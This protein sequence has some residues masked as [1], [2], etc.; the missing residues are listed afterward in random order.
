MHTNKP[1][2]SKFSFGSCFESPFSRGKNETPGTTTA[3]ASSSRATTSSKRQPRNCEHARL[4]VVCEP[5]KLN[6]YDILKINEYS[7]YI[8]L[9]VF[10]S[11]IELYGSEFAYG[12]HQFPFTG[13]FEMVPRDYADLGA[14]FRF[15]QTI[16]LGCTQFTCHQVYQIV[17]E[18]GQR[19]TG[20]SY[21]LIHNNC[22]HFCDYMAQFLCGRGI[23]SWVN[24]LATI[25]G[26]VPFLQRF[27]PRD[28]LT[29]RATLQE[30]VTIMNNSNSTSYANVI[31]KEK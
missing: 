27:L 17:E 20:S 5:V 30:S 19:F 26:Y 11:G 15:R 9:G 12:G 28:W 8:G 2:F 16:P 4:G 25:T 10:H 6:V 29:P 24:R 14:N 31:N 3:T 7:S 1:Q 23:P 22:N 18:L 21:H 13:I